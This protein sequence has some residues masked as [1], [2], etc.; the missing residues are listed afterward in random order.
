VF[1]K[2]VFVKPCSSNWVDH[3]G[4]RRV[5]VIAGPGST[6]APFTGPAVNTVKYLTITQGRKR[7]GWLTFVLVTPWLAL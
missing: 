7:V 3:A 5:A 6:T 4:D 1:I 2:L